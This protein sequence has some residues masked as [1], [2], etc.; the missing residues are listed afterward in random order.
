MYHSHFC[1]FYFPLYTGTSLASNVWLEKWTT[2]SANK[3]KDAPY[4]VTYVVLSTTVLLLAFLRSFAFFYVT[5]K[6][7]EN[8]HSKMLFSI[9][10]APVLFFDTNPSGRMINRFAKDIGYM[11]ETLPW[12]LLLFLQRMLF[13]VGAVGLV[14]VSNPWLNLGSVPFVLLSVYLARRAF[15]PARELK[16]LEAI[17][18][19]PI[20]AHFS[21]TVEGIVTI[22]SYR[23]QGHF[24]EK[25][26]RLVVRTK[27]FFFLPGTV[28]RTDMNSIYMQCQKLIFLKKIEIIARIV[29]S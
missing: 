21:E 19:S 8:L 27:C 26:Y 10:R 28:Q 15:G 17:S 4:L 16:R 1:F 29:L 20:Y 24:T 11:D 14:S 13:F 18:T 2:T 9:L 7:S 6:S 5:L 12:Y 25:Y 23:R 3:E 22:R